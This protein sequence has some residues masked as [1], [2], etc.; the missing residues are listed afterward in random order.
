M[1]PEAMSWV[2]SHSTNEAVDVLDI[3]G[4]NINGSPRL[5]FP[6]AT[7][8]TVL[9]IS[10]DDG[11]DIVADASTWV[12]ERSYDVVVCCEVFEHT[13]LWPGI[14]ATVYE[15]LA[16]GG[17]LITTMAGPGREPHSAIDGYRCR[18]GEHY[19][20]VEAPVLE[21]ALDALGFRDIEVNEQLTSHDVRAIAYR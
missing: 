4:R 15:A 2:A 5:L 3:G 18:E 1:H 7:S 20:N 14:L 12:P 6:N 13:A 21:A 16:D 17:K 10:P 8:Y 19:G 11:V 9:D